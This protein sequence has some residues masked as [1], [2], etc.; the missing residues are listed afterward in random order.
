MTPW[1]ASA[2]T[3]VAMV[4]AALLLLAGGAAL[5]APGGGTDPT[6]VR[7]ESSGAATTTAPTESGDD[8]AS[9]DDE[10][11][12]DAADGPAPAATPVPAALF[13][14]LRP[15]DIGQGETML[16]WVSAPQAASAVLDI[17]GERHSLIAESN[18]VYWGLVGMPLDADIGSGSL[19]VTA[20]DRSGETIETVETTYHVVPVERPVDALTLTDEQS[21][22]LTPEA[23]TEELRLRSQQFAEF[24]RGRR[25]T[26]LFELPLVAPVTTQFGQGRSYNGGPVG[27][28]HTG[29]DFGAQ[30][31]TAVHA[32]A[33]ARV[34]WVGEMPIRGNSVILDHGA[35]AKTGYHHLS[36]VTVEVGQEVAAAEVIGQVGSTGLSTGPHLHWELTIWGV[37]VDPA[38]WTLRDFTP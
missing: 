33:A 31:G 28:F 21:A 8:P 38:T 27:G 13:V 14:D 2:R 36:A 4:I 18:G 15:A 30:E 24:D 35:G 6:A 37:N 12:A 3:R 22:V 25:W 34:A 1:F 5:A 9:T 10:A 19:T 16:V 11:D 17:R 26:G 7:A 20:R 32:A 23:G 29:T